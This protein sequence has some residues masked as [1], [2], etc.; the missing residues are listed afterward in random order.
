MKARVA[1]CVRLFA[2]PD[3]PGKKTGVGSLSLLQGILPAQGSNPGLPHTLQADSLPAEP[4]PEAQ[5]ARAPP[6]AG[7]EKGAATS[8]HSFNMK[9]SST[10]REK[11]ASKCSAQNYPVASSFFYNK[12]SESLLRPPGSFPIPPPLSHPVSSNPAILAFPPLPSPPLQGI[13]ALPNLDGAPIRSP[14]SRRPSS[15]SS[16]CVPTA[17]RPQRASKEH[18]ENKHTAGHQAPRTGLLEAVP[19]ELAWGQ[20]RPSR[21]LERKSPFLPSA[22]G[23][24][25]CY[26][27]PDKTNPPNH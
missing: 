3:S 27:R 13:L 9:S 4:P 25:S 6:R 8:F 14:H 17:P 1:Q 19:Q 12:E 20:P 24:F 15:H 7:A 18:L 5:P 10:Q 21:G 26:L 16:D 22:S 2:T 11:G 23:L